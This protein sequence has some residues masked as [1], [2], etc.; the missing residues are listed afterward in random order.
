MRIL[1][2]LMEQVRGLS[3]SKKDVL[4]KPFEGYKPVLRAG[5]IQ[6]GQI[7]EDNYVYV[8]EDLIKE[9]QLLKEGDI[10]IAASS[11]SLS[12]VG[13]AAMV[14]NNMEAT[15]G[16][17]CKV[18]R[19]KKEVIYQGYFKH[20]FETKYYKRTI[21]SLAE[22]ANINNLRTGHFDNLEI[23]LPPLDQQ[24][25]IAAILDAADTYRQKTKALITKYDALTQSLFLDM[26]GDP[27]NNPKGW[28]I[29]TVRDII[30]EAKYG[31]SSKAVEN[32]SYCYL[33]MNNITYKG[34]M[35]YSKLKYINMAEEQVYKYE[36][37][38]G[39]ILFN[40]TNSKELVGKT[41]II[42]SDEKMILAG[43]LIRVRMQ[44]RYNPYFLWAHLNSKWAKQTLENMCKN[45]VGMANINAQ[46]LQNIIVL[47]PPFDLQNQ[48]AERVQAIEAQKAQAQ[49][50]LVQAEDLFNSLLQ[51]AFKGE[52]V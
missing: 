28:G 34:Y 22:G 51:R 21:R 38:K 52:L 44:E 1:G 29:L 18:L 37:K 17:F 14:D 47:N 9:K 42:T 40:R 23:P 24:K 45:I 6:Q 33:R 43:Y 5:N 16:A 25:K 35:N 13:K 32:G 3:Y 49:A 4:N 27:V 8:H 10:L 31:T 12:I 26:F 41:G 39:D 11:G 15:F 48:F 46:E 20:Y 19:P 30:E 50:S 2:D 7:V 36:T